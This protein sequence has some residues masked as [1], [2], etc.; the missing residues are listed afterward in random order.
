MGAGLRRQQSSGLRKYNDSY[1]SCIVLVVVFGCFLWDND[2]VPSSLS[3]FAYAPQMQPRIGAHPA[4]TAENVDKPTLAFASTGQRG[5][6]MTNAADR[7]TRCMETWV[8]HGLLFHLLRFF[9][10]LGQAGSRVAAWFGGFG[11]HCRNG[12]R[13]LE[14]GL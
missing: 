10:C 13:N 7:H 9:I 6:Q 14:I 1:V 5:T 2:S 4:V 12:F 11:L 8:G 3:C